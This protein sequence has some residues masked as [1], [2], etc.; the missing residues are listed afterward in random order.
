MF[1]Q[2][3]LKG[4]KNLVWEENLTS[5]LFFF[6]RMDKKFFYEQ[7][8]K[9]KTFAWLLCTFISLTKEISRSQK[10]TLNVGFNFYRVSGSKDHVKF[11]EQV[12]PKNTLK[13][14]KNLL[15]GLKFLIQVLLI[16]SFLERTVDPE[17]WVESWLLWVA[18]QLDL[19]FEGPQ[20]YL[21]W[22]LR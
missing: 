11:V 8:S 13:N 10:F 21:C 3:L 7:S 9:E 4:K 14:C 5:L 20:G 16:L 6:H 12:I 19:G 17:F 15:G 18:L 22:S 2:I 1:I